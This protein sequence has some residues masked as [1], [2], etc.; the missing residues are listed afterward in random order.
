[1]YYDLSR[2]EGRNEKAHHN[3]LNRNISSGAAMTTVL[4]ALALGG[5]CEWKAFNAHPAPRQRTFTRADC[6]ACH[7][8]VRL[9]EL[10]ARKQGTRSA[11]AFADTKSPLGDRET[12]A[13]PAN[14]AEIKAWIQPAS[15]H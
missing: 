2:S 15:P 13:L 9:K 14:H 6:L 3:M 1:M 10:M 4:A 5:F 8:Q 7:S 12:V 11:D